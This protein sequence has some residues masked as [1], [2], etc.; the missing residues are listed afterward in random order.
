MSP[1]WTVLLGIYLPPS[2]LLANAIVPVRPAFKT[3]LQ[4]LPITSSQQFAISCLL[5]IVLLRF[6]FI[7]V[8]FGLTRDRTTILKL[9]AYYNLCERETVI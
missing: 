9:V 6:I 8:L 1:Q 7:L 3:F 4:T 2:G 5:F